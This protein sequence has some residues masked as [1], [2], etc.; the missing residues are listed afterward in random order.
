LVPLGLT[1]GAVLGVVKIDQG[2]LLGFQAV[3]LSF[4]R[5]VFVV[6]RDGDRV[7]LHLAGQRDR[8]RGV[9]RDKVRWIVELV[10]LLFAINT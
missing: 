9:R 3:R 8:L 10:C 1:L 2:G 4:V 5:V 6:L 7:A